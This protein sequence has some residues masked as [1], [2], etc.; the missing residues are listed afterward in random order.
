MNIEEIQALHQEI[1]LFKQFLYEVHPHP[2]QTLNE[3]FEAEKTNF[4]GLFKNFHFEVGGQKKEQEHIKSTKSSIQNTKISD[5]GEFRFKNN[6]NVLI[7]LKEKDLQSY[8]K[9]NLPEDVTCLDDLDQINLNYPLIVFVYY[10]ERLFE[11]NF[12]DK[13]NQMH[14]KHYYFS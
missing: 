3:I 11:D 4:I 7:S 5:P 2:D 8:I 9:K 1:N 14:C 12:I 10:C 13:V 6:L